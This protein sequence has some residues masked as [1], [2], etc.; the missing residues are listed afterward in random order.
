MRCIGMMRA[1]C[2]MAASSPASRHSWRNTLFSTCRADG[3]KPKLMFDSPS[4]VQTPGISVLMRRIP[5]IV[6]MPSWRLSSIPVASGERVAVEQQVAGL[7]AVA[8]D[9]EVADAA[10]D[11]DLA[12]GGAGLTFLVDAHADDGGAVLACQ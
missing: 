10:G 2:T 7:E 6:S 3:L 4:T 8:V 9:G 12:V 1:A 11:V 5:S